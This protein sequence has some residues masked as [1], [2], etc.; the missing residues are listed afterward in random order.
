[1]FVFV[2]GCAYINFP[3]KIIYLY[4]FPFLTLRTCDNL[5]STTVVHSPS[6]SSARVRGRSSS[7]SETAGVGSRGFQPLVRAELCV[8]N[9]EGC[10]CW[11]G[12]V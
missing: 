4:I 3:P 11:F 7:R 1:M 6:Q 8:L 9:G 10:V 5:G 2:G 12:L